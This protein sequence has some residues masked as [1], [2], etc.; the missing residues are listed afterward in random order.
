[1]C[2]HLNTELSFCT[3]TFAGFF[4][5][6]RSRLKKW[7]NV[8][9]YQRLDISQDPV[10]QGFAPETYDLIIA[11]NVLHAT[12]DM[13]ETLRNTRSMLKPGGHLLLLEAV[14]AEP[15]TMSVALL[16]GWWLSQ[17]KYRGPDGPLLA[18]QVWDR[19]LSEN[20]FSGLDLCVPDYPGNSY[21]L[22]NVFCTTKV[23]NIKPE[24]E[25]TKVTV[26]TSME[27]LE[28]STTDPALNKILDAIKADFAPEATLKSILDC[29]SDENPLCIFIDGP[30][31]SIWKDLDETGF[32]AVKQL[33]LKT[34]GLL[35]VTVDTCEVHSQTIK[36]F[37]RTFR[38]E[39]TSKNMLHVDQLP[40][41]QASAVVQLAKHL[42]SLMR[43]QSTTGDQEFVWRDGMIQVPRLTS[44]KSADDAFNLDAGLPVRR[45]QQIAE[46][47]NPLRLTSDCVG[48]LESIYFGTSNVLK[49]DLKG[50]EIIIQNE[51]TGLVFRDLLQVLGQIPWKTE[52]DGPGHEGVGVV[53]RVGSNVTH[54][55][56]G[57]RV[58]YSAIGGA[59]GTHL[60]I[61]SCF[62]QRLPDGLNDADAVGLS[63]AYSTAIVVVQRTAR[64]QKNESILIHSASGATGQACVR[65]AQHIGAEVFVTA[66]TP[67]KRSFL[68]DTFQIPETHIFSSRNSEFA[69]GI[70]RIVAGRGLDVVVNSL[71]GRLLRE[72][73][74]L[75]A[76]F[77]VS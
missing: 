11:G 53:H 75:I 67:E 69:N 47:S 37:L 73:W 43:S 61:Q 44:L 76:D 15:S 52:D 1:M 17:D 16:P 46:H 27:S 3:N 48:T 38:L 66:G 54:V 31:H 21:Q 57:D 41:E 6:A 2:R 4:D 65:L 63:V 42:R 77:G 33:L 49:Q 74:E 8:V 72:T 26:L 40:S 20:G 64:L 71:S 12:P 58:F 62:A 36:G 14:V 5:N 18:S 59:L 68:R 55:E 45:L 51:K 19:M 39:D 25:N 56:V 35:W 7:A 30:R 70:K 23:P 13:A 32:H 34:A 9:R 28:Q 24:M 60:R 29:D 50:D 22:M 10:P